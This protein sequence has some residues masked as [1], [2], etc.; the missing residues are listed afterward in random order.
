MESSLTSESTLD[1]I[2][3]V[4]MMGREFYTSSEILK[5][6]TN[7]KKRSQSWFDQTFSMMMASSGLDCSTKA[8]I[9]RERGLAPVFVFETGADFSTKG[10]KGRPSIDKDLQNYFIKKVILMLTS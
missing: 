10:K 3:R 1:E 9:W 7:L 4:R 8:N 6:K 5:S 2:E